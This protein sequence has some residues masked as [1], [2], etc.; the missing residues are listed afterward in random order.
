MA[1]SKRA[2]NLYQ[3]G[4]VWYG[5]V[6]VDGTKHRRSLQTADPREAERRLIQWRASLS[7][8]HGTIE[9]TWEQAVL[10][11]WDAHV[12]QW[13]PK[14]ATGYQKILVLLDR[15]FAGTAWASITKDRLLTYMSTRRAEGAS[16]ATINRNLAVISAIANTVREL[17]GW[18]D[19]NPVSQLP[20]RP[21]R[22]KRAPFVRPTPECIERIFAHMHG[23]FGELCRFAL[24]TGLRKDEIA[25]L[26]R[27][28]CVGGEVQLFD[29]KNRGAAVV[30]LCDEARAIVARQPQAQR[31]L[32]E[33]RNRGP[34]LRVTEMWREVVARAGA[35]AAKEQV[36]FTP[37]RF[38]DLRHEFAI[39]YLKA[40]GSLYQLQ[41]LLR[42]STIG[43]T[44]WYL[45]YLTPDQAEQAK[46]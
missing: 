23:T 4:S 21:R 30:P 19:A 5:C 10:L 32:F 31:F 27:R 33:T 12:S 37:L 42:H 39:R 13:K 46:R 11:W 16:V 8:Y 28:H 15:H 36:P 40:G 26:E 1:R 9:H 43:Q 41:K 38:H 44:E 22:E 18:P 14:T 17:E 3:R 29:Q 45:S 35:R 6:T 25:Q 7:P 20:R 2:R 24:L 34:F